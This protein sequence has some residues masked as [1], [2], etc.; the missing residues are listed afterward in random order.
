MGVSGNVL[1]PIG[2]LGAVQFLQCGK[3]TANDF[4]FSAVLTLWRAF[5]WAAVEPNTTMVC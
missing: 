3:I 2:A 4:F 1:S 5:F